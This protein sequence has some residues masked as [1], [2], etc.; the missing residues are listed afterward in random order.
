MLNGKGGTLLV[1]IADDGTVLGI[2][3]D[4]RTLRKPPLDGFQLALTDIVKTHLGVEHMS[5]L[6]TAFRAD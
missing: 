6:K 4:L 1:G 3:K 5:C 2:E